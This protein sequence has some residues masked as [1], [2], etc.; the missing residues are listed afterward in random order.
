MLINLNIMHN[1]AYYAHRLYSQV[2]LDLM[3]MALQTANIH[4]LPIKQFLIFSM[5]FSAISLPRNKNQLIVGL[6]FS[7][8][9]F[10]HTSYGM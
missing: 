6:M 7:K 4:L 5:P 10:T 2:M 1:F 8:I 3:L 9:K